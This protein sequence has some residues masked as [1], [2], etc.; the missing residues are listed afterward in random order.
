MSDA[1]STRHKCDHGVMEEQR[2]S[3]VVERKR[4]GGDSR[5][6]KENAVTNQIDAASL[7]LCDGKIS[8]RDSG[9]TNERHKRPSKIWA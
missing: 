1:T 3:R 7:D 5:R 8:N 6:E 2:M 9:M 4:L